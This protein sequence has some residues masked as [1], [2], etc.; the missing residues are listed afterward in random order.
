MR[1]HSGSD[2]A[3]TP[4]RED[5]TTAAWAVRKTNNCCRHGR[6]RGPLTTHHDDNCQVSNHK[7]CSNAGRLKAAAFHYNQGIRDLDM[8]P[9][10]QLLPESVL[11]LTSGHPFCHFATPVCF[12][13]LVLPCNIHHI[14]S[15]HTASHFLQSKLTASSHKWNIKLNASC[16]GR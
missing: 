3:A 16:R 13:A 11:L 2:T 10:H 6:C 15:Q 8:P 1:A 4:A 7:P 5:V 9:S 14:W 12:L